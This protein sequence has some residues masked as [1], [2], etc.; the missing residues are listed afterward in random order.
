[1]KAPGPWLYLHTRCE[2]PLHTRP[3]ADLRHVCNNKNG[4]GACPLLGAFEDSAIQRQEGKMTVNSARTLQGNHLESLMLIYDFGQ[5][6]R[7]FIKLN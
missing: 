6:A 7:T 1:M 4:E 5:V 3:D 2:P